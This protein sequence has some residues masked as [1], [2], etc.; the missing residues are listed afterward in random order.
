MVR[1]EPR[2]RLHVRDATLDDLEAVLALLD[3][4]AMREVAEDFTDL[5]PYAAA[6]TE[7]LTADHST[8]LVGQLHGVVV[9]T[10]QVT[11]QRRMMY[12]ADDSRV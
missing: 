3:E 4:D 8:V 10:A 6:M 11:W 1:T 2:P 5:T 9:A 7:I 12:G